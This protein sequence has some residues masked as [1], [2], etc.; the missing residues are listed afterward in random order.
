MLASPS[1]GP[2]AGRDRCN[3]PR[4]SVVDLRAPIA[5]KTERNMS[6]DRDRAALLFR[7][8]GQEARFSGGLAGVS[9]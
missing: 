4:R 6:S 1:L 9:I 2:N 8:L 5:R 3:A 7:V